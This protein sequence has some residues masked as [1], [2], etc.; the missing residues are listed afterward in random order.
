M[1][2]RPIFI[3]MLIFLGH[4]HNMGNLL[5]LDGVYYLYKA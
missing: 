3:V 4:S 1:H 2:N 5:V